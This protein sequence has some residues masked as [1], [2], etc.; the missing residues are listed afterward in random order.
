MLMQNFDA[1]HN[2]IGNNTNAIRPTLMHLAATLHI[3]CL[4]FTSQ[5]LR[6]NEDAIENPILIQQFVN[7]ALIF[8]DSVFHFSMFFRV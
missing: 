8:V 7:F 4:R 5:T 1:L 6:Q 2:I 3:A